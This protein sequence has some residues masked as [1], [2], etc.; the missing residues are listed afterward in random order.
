M[1][2]EYRN[3]RGYTLEKL[4]ELCEISWRNLQRIENGQ[5]KKTKFETI[6]KI[7]TKLNMDDKDIIKLIK[8]TGK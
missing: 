6:S 3:K 7:I 8:E 1:L 2:K 4:A 5:Y